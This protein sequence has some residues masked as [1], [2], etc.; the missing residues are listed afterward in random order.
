MRAY[1]EIM[2]LYYNNSG[3]GWLSVRLEEGLANVTT[4]NDWY[5][6]NVIII[7]NDKG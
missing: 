3:A 7:E 2:M 6:L 5:F 1:N 4:K